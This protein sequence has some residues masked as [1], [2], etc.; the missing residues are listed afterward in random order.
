MKVTKVNNSSEQKIIILKNKFLNKVLSGTIKGK[1]IEVK[2][3]AI[4]VLKKR[5]NLKPKLIIEV[6]LIIL[7]DA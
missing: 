5:V 7:F 3:E 6:S 4:K 2:I 1:I